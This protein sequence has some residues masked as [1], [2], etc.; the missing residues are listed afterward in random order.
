MK[1]QFLATASHQLRTPMTS[2]LAFSEL[3]TSRDVPASRK[4]RWIGQIHEQADRMITTINTMLNVSQIEAGRL[5]LQM[6]D[7]DAAE[8]FDSV[9]RDLS[10]NADHRL[11]MRVNARLSRIRADKHRFRQVVENLV[12]NAMKYTPEN[13]VIRI[14]A[15]KHRD[16]LVDFAVSDS[17]PGVPRDEQEHLFTPFYRVPGAATDKVSGT[18]LGLYIARSIAELHGGD[19][20]VESAPGAGSSF[21]FTFPSSAPA[22]E[23]LSD[24]ANGERAAGRQPVGSS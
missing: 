7:F 9:I 13:G 24:V 4:E 19:V 15:E 21:H 6:E 2:I 3:L 12:D 22:V 11:E 14:T 10:V 23:R 20:W 8:V 16:G 1:S 17:G 18:G 5:D